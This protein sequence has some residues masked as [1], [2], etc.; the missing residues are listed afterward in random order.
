MKKYL[1]DSRH[2]NTLLSLLIVGA[3]TVVLAVFFDVWFTINDDVMIRDILS[4]A[5]TGTPN[6]HC[7]QM[8]YP[9][10]LLISSLY[11]LIPALPWY[12]LFMGFCHC[13][14]AFLI[15]RRLFT[16][17]EDVEMNGGK[18]DG[19]NAEDGKSDG[20]KSN[21]GR[22]S[23]GN[24]A[25]GKTKN[26]KPAARK[27][28]AGKMKLLLAVLA[29]L[30]FTAIL[31]GKVLYIQYT[32]T[33]AL[34]AGTAIFLFVTTPDECSPAEFNRENIVS[35]ILFILAFCMRTEMVLL[36][37]PLVAAAGI[38]K[39]SAGT[40]K[41]GL[42]FFSRINYC[43]YL[44][45]VLVVALGMGACYLC[46]MAAYSSEEW[47]EFRTFFDN[48]TELFDFLGRAPEYEGNEEFYDR[49]GLSE[50]QVELLVNYNF[51]LDEEIDSELLQ[52]IIDYDLEE[53]EVG[54]FRYVISDGF[55][56]YRWQMVNLIDRPWMVVI[57]AGYVLV[58]AAGLMNRH[59]GI[60]WQ[61]GLLG[62]MRTVSW[63]Y[64]FMRGRFYDRVNHSL[65]L[66]EILIL[67][68]MLLV[69][70]RRICA[71]FEKKKV[72]SWLANPDGRHGNAAVREDQFTEQKDGSDKEKS[73]KAGEDRKDH[74]NY[75]KKPSG[76]E[77]L[78]TAFCAGT[79]L[80]FG[81]IFGVYAVIGIQDALADKAAMEAEYAT[82][83]EPLQEYCAAHP[84][85]YFLIDVYSYTTSF[86][87]VLLTGDSDYRNYDICGGWSAKSPV[88]AKKL[89]YAGI[90][91]LT[92]D[93][94]GQ[95]DVLFISRDDREVDWL[96]A[97]Y[98]VKGY[99]VKV[100]AVDH[101]D[102]AADEGY[103]VY[104]VALDE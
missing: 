84:D 69:E 94:A 28:G 86:E 87:P 32:V 40:G 47:Q 8:L 99:D 71:E 63:M 6:A 19:A 21:D 97:Y 45:T 102:T 58:L 11:R 9:L 27:P 35:M 48:R 16:W 70:M 89:A 24:R 75:R 13:L 79:A 67:L 43:K 101:I 92:A 14:C 68:A 29:V 93:L 74:F 17:A 98:A 82:C 20:G 103:T 61:L 78:R 26:G 42:K 44:I 56:Y 34:L 91:D 62:V 90:E 104:Q 64:I 33:C 83:Y 3:G 65:Y 7:I 51:A 10:G 72:F 57:V 52:T 5:Y 25:A 80:A 31:L 66:C 49:I 30:G 50:E 36:L 95:E 2:K 37:C 88:Y 39:W 54:Y 18:A 96:A 38:Y 76:G 4:G 100:T 81:L 22:L 1:S 59:W 60:W 53:R 73:R 85:Q 23:D 41:V 55:A 46:D 12:G 77:T 15:L